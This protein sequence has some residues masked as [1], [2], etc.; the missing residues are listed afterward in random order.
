MEA[1]NPS[2][3]DKYAARCSVVY[4]LLYFLINNL[5]GAHAGESQWWNLQAQVAFNRLITR[6]CN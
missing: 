4:D 5:T 3:V 2:F 6:I 1:W